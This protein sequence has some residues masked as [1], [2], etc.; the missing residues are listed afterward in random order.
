MRTLHQNEIDTVAGGPL[1]IPV[2]IAFGKGAVAGAAAASKSKVVLG[3]AA[4]GVAA[5]V[6]N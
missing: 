3:L 2:V 6:G 4:A 5:G 1:F